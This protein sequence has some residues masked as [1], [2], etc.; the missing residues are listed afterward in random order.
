MIWYFQQAFAGFVG[1]FWCPGKDMKVRGDEEELVWS[2]ELWLEM[3]IDCTAAARSLMSMWS[4]PP[5][6][7]LRC[8]GRTQ[9]GTKMYRDHTQFSLK[10]IG[11]SKKTFLNISKTFEKWWNTW[12][13]NIASKYWGK[14]K[15]W[16]DANGECDFYVRN[17][18]T[19]IFASESQ[20]L[21]VANVEVLTPVNSILEERDKWRPQNIQNSW[22]HMKSH[23]VTLFEY[24]LLS[25]IINYS[26]TF[27]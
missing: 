17:L 6:R 19:S 1:R 22:N 26:T 20:Q 16:Q 11:H 4:I 27:W 3:T 14:T 9:I 7:W 10:T 5:K 12:N 15:Q 13:F 23:H 21:S 24:W 25:N 8:N 18:N 2:L